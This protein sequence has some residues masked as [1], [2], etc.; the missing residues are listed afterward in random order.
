VNLDAIRLS[1]RGCLEH[2]SA[3][4]R[5]QIRRSMRLYEKHGELTA[6][7]ATNI[8]EAMRYYSEMELLHQRYWL[9][10]GQAGAHAYPFYG[11]FHRALLANCLPRGT[12]E[13]VRIAAGDKTI[14]YV[15]NFVR[16]GWVYAYQTGLEYDSDSKMKPGLVAHYLCIEK[17]LSEGAHGYDFLAG[18]SRYKRSFGTPGPDMLE[19]VLQRPIAKLR[20][21]SALREVKRTFTHAKLED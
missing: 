12:A 11:K 6:Q 9:S 20:I 10:R 7:R 14:G 21:E 4:T 1:G 15:Y 19:L 18:D 2:L 16:D 13:L 8:D 3:N 5:Y 17:H